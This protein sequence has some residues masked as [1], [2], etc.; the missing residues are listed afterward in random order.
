M[1]KAL[2]FLIFHAERLME[3]ERKSRAERNKI[4]AEIV[5]REYERIMPEGFEG[6]IK[7]Q[8]NESFA[9]FIEEKGLMDEYDSWV[10]ECE[11]EVKIDHDI[12]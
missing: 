10:E 9:W 7:S 8:M 1:F 11:A 2:L 4:I 3:A 12:R 6:A 5:C